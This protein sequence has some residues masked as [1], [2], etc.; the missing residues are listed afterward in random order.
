MGHVVVRLVSSIAVA[1]LLVAPAGAESVAAKRMQ[2]KDNVDAGR[3][4][5][6]FLTTDAGIAVADGYVD[7][8]STGVSLHVFSQ[9]T[10]NDVCLWALAGDCEIKGGNADV[11][12]C[13]SDDRSAKVLI[14]PGKAKV[15]FKRSIGFELDALASQLPV[16]MILRAG[17]AAYCAVCGDGGADVVVKDGSDGQQVLAKTCEAAPCPAEPSACGLLPRPEDPVVMTAAQIGSP[18]VGIGP[19]NLVAFRWS[20]GWQ[21]IPVQVDERAT[22]SFNNVYNGMT[23]PIC[24]TSCGGGITA[25]DYADM[26]TF[27]GAD[28]TPSMDADDEVAFMASD[29]G[30]VAPNVAQ[31]DGTFAGSGVEVVVTDP[32]APSGAWRVYLFRQD[33]SLDQYA[34]QQYV[35]YQFSLNSGAYSTTYNIV[36]GPNPENSIVSSAAYARHFSDRWIQD[37][38]RIFAGG[39]TGVDILDRHKTH[40]LNCLRDEDSFVDDEGA[41]VANRSGGVRAIRSYVGANSGPL[42]QRQHVFYRARE[43]STTFIRVHDIP[44]VFD[45]IDYT[46]AA[47]GMLLYDNNNAGGLLIDGTPDSFTSGTLDWQLVTGAQ[48]S[49]TMVPQFASTIGD[50]SVASIYE[51]DTMPFEPQCTGDS[52]SYGASGLRIA[53]LAGNL[54]NTDPR[55]APADTLTAK[56]YIYYD[57]PELTVTDA[58]QRRSW[59]LNPLVAT[60]SPWP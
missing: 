48:G 20:D 39:A 50:L 42:T 16:A 22:I 2:V 43:D 13:R 46:A 9:T 15:K 31:P 59:A 51:D 23:A 12:K 45:L 7:A 21:Q 36:D 57:A 14:K 52:V 10:A 32:L 35:S 8:T 30:G 19:A 34:G 44:P 27:T 58:E 6:S 37:E 1:A 38:L 40:V 53:T 60:G 29:A 54:P 33:G 5:V 28:P 4:Q 55:F 11:L 47:T 18:L 24:G 56:R 17:G 26:G 41:F 25:P 3:Q 49:L